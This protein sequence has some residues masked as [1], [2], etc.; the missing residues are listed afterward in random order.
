MSSKYDSF[1]AYAAQ[2]VDAGRIISQ[3]SIR[4]DCVYFEPKGAPG[5]R[6]KSG[7]RREKLAPV[8]GVLVDNGRILENGGVM[9][10]I[11]RL[12]NGE[13]F[14]DSATGRPVYE[15]CGIGKRAYE[16]SAKD[17][18]FVV[19]VLK[20]RKDGPELFFGPNSLRDRTS[21]I[22]A[23]FKAGFNPRTI[24][25]DG[26]DIFGWLET[27]MTAGDK[28][29]AVAVHR[30]TQSPASHQW[31]TIQT[32]E[33]ATTYAPQNLDWHVE[34]YLGRRDYETYRNEQ[35]KIAAKAARDA[36]KKEGQ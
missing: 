20:D 33:G 31:L 29:P 2:F 30:L 26:R 24:A 22:A 12:P 10:D 25:T 32:D 19:A 16:T 15:E 6:A 5:I 17:R 35:A 36:E 21:M 1:E 34:K 9:H 27:V 3:P 14:I 7:F 23:A 11:W 13:P 8:Y 18:R 4:V 28:Y